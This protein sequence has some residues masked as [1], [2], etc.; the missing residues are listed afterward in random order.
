M[1]LW[2]FI[3]TGTAAYGPQTP[4]KSDIDIVLMWDDSIKLE[5][6]LF[7]KGI[8]I[9]YLKDRS[10]ENDYPNIT[11]Y[12][13]IA[14]LRFNIVRCMHPDDFAWWKNRTEHMKRLPPISGREDRLRE[15]KG[16]PFESADLENL[17]F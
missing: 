1:E 14:G 16:R 12:F 15:F 2:D 9:E 5:Q 3:V 4:G 11:F 6:A 13:Q 17:L 7:D 8:E 10:P